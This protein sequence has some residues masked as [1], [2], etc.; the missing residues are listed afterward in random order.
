MAAYTMLSSSI[1][2]EKI[3]N[4][5]RNLQVMRKVMSINPTDTLRKELEDGI[6]LII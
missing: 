4:G 3:G 1:P 6:G 2:K 5:F